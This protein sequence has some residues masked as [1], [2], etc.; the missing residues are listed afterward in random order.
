MACGVAFKAWPPAGQRLEIK[1]GGKSQAALRPA[2]DGQRTEAPKPNSAACSSR[3]RF[4][5]QG[6]A[7]FGAPRLRTKA[8]PASRAA[9]S[10]PPR[11]LQ[12]ASAGT[13]SPKRRCR[14]AHA[15]TPPVRG[16]SGCVGFGFRSLFESKCKAPK[17]PP[18]HGF[19]D[20]VAIKAGAKRR[21]LAGRLSEP[22]RQRAIAWKSKQ[23]A[24]R[25]PALRSAAGGQRTEAPKPNSVPRPRLRLVWHPAN[26]GTPALER[27][28]RTPLA[29]KP[30]VQGRSGGV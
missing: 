2:E 1:A 3:T 30:P 27:R 28:H 18:S 6:C 29:K 24:N 26:P 4:R 15:Q 23:A 9:A 12:N 19:S 25:K 7:L 13:Q 16:R 10:A 8:E 5:A 21:W 11:Q 22:G 17:T 20:F 14:N